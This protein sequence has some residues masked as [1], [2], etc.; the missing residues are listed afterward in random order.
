MLCF[1]VIFL[2]RSFKYDSYFMYMF[3][4]CS[5]IRKMNNVNICTSNL[6]YLTE[7]SS[8]PVIEILNCVKA[9][10]KIF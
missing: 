3:L 6:Q 5:D 4:K 1:N 10:E 2:I 9:I 7:N 8:S